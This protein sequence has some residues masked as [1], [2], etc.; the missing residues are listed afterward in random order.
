MNLSGSGVSWTLG[1]R[2][3]SLGIG[4]RGTFL[5]SGIPKTGVYT[6]QRIG[7]SSSSR[8]RG[9]SATYTGVS[10]KVEVTDD[11]TVYFE[12]ADGN[13]LPEH[14]VT[15]TKK[16]Q[17]DA[18]RDLIQQKCDEINAQ[19][20]ALGGIHL[21]T[22][23]PNSMP[24]YQMQRYQEPPPTKPIPGRP[25]LLVSLFKRK[26]A[27]HEE[28]NTEK[29]LQYEQALKDWQAAKRRFEESERRRKD[30]VE[31]DIYSDLGA[32]EKFL[33]ENLQ[34]IIWPRETT[35]ATEIL[36]EGQ[37]IFL[38]VDLPEIE[39][40]P[41]K[42][43]S[44][45]QRG[46]KLSVKEMSAAQ[47]QRLYMRHIHGVGFRIIGETFAALPTAQEV[48]LSAFS[49][50]PKAATGQVTEEY[51]YSVRVERTA[52][53]R[54]RFDNLQNLDIVEALAQF[55]L[56]RNMTKTGSFKAIEPLG[57]HVV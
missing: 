38:D 1:P 27:R 55:D 37:R 22:P 8:S 50:R 28:E 20:E 6:R 14:L 49:Q 30:F 36:D 51:L 34:S 15:A 32:M 3:A 48:V 53:S 18:I 42:K 4:K 25:G 17:G 52:W 13:P 9:L 5:N 2:G 33:E 26:R 46:Y 31:R 44:V 35:V 21:Y 10:I 54:I 23:D 24:Q 7:G 40:M 41:N 47:V 19:I 16:Q 56:R 11:G 12:D 45:P 39:D 57:P 29:E 43:A